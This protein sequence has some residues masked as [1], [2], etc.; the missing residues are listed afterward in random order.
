VSAG[1]AAMWI[2]SGGIVLAV[3]VVLAVSGLDGVPGEWLGILVAAALA[4]VAFVLG[5][6]D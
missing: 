1:R 6:L 4:G 3:L 2:I 5:Y